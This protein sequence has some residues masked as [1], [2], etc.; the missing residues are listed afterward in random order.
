MTPA[1]LRRFTLLGTLYFAQ[2]LPFGFFVQ[3]LPVL[4]RAAGV[5]LGAIGLAGLLVLPWALKFLWAPVVDRRWWPRLGR[6]RSWILG[7]QLAGTVVLTAIAVVPGADALPAL[8]AAMLVLNL[9][10]A[11]Q[12]IATDG[13]AVELLPPGERGFAN[14]LQVAGYRVG[15][16]VGGGALLGAYETLGHRGTFGVMAA[17]T[18]LASL[19]VLL[20][21]EPTTVATVPGGAAPAVHFLRLPGARRVLALLLLYKAGEALATGMLKPMLVDHGLQSS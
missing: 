5:S 3:A 7:M 16:V 1:T 4:L 13:L 8:M 2:G 21:P 20:T 17:L 15:M 6:R 18:A 9:I 10:A 11:T 19:P 14:G 12:D